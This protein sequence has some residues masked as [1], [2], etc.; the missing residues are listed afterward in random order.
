VSSRKV[1]RIKPEFDAASILAYPVVIAAV[2]Q[3]SAQLFKVVLYSF[4]DRRLAL[5]RFVN[6]AGFPSAHSA[7][8][9]SLA[10]AIGIRRGV[11][12]D[13]FAV[14]F[15][16]AAVVVY[17]SFR[18]RG[19]VQRHAETINELLARNAASSGDGTDSTA[20]GATG[21]GG[22]WFGT[23]RPARGHTGRLAGAPVS[24]NVGHNLPE[25]AVGVTWGVAWAVLLA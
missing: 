12:S 18:L 16:L 19:H 25:V 17:D 7:F 6:A 24:E 11:G 14:A 8:V 21:A 5:D 2:S 20:S 4:R 13:L 15:V 3:L 10:T 1:A 9:V 23:G 22:R